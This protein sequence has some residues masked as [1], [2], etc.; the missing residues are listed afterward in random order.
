MSTWMGLWR[1]AQAGQQLQP[2]HARQADVEHH[3]VE[4]FGGQGASASSALP[5]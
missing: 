4:F 2:V 3:Q 1:A 5:T